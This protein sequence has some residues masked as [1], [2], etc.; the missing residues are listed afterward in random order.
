MFRARAGV[1]RP[2]RLASIVADIAPRINSNQSNHSGAYDSGVSTD[3]FLEPFYVYDAVIPQFIEVQDVFF[4]KIVARAIGNAEWVIYHRYNG[5]FLLYENIS[6]LY[7]IE[8]GRIRIHFYLNI[9]FVL[10]ITISTKNIFMVCDQ[11]NHR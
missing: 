4:F 7:S 2:I 8:I 6:N 9:N 10:S 3:S 5:F 1:V 11:I